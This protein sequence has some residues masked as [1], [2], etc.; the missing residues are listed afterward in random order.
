M[1]NPC[2]GIEP[3]WLV[4]GNEPLGFGAP[5]DVVAFCCVVVGISSPVDCVSSGSVDETTTPG[6]R[7]R[8]LSTARARAHPRKPS[9]NSVTPIRGKV[10]P[11]NE[12]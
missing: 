2:G 1:T 9:E 6:V 10:R 3:D 12:G 7:A 8:A 11:K 4:I 5:V